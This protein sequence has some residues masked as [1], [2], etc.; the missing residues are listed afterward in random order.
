MGIFPEGENFR[1]DHGLGRLV[2]LGLKALL[3]LHPPISPLTSSG[4]RNGV[5][6]SEVGYTPAMPRR[7]DHSV[8]YDTRWHWGEKIKIKIKKYK[9]MSHVKM[10]KH[11]F[12]KHHVLILEPWAAFADS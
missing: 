5:P 12:E 3:A 9:W 10:K 7:E 1:G 11:L 2:E 8:H 4:Q 6:T